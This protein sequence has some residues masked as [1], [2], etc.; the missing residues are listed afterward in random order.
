MSAA[1]Q[2]A[3]PSTTTTST[4]DTAGRVADAVAGAA[5]TPRRGAR[6]TAV[7]SG[8]G[9]V[10]KTFVAANL[11]AALARRGERVL[12]LDA[13][14]GLANLDVVLNLTARTTL[15]D[16]FTGRATLE[17][18]LQPAPGGFTVLL[19]GSG[20]IEY[21][22]MTPQVR[23]QLIALMAEVRPRFD[24]VLLDTGAGIADVVLFTVSLADELLVVTTPEPTALADAYATLKVLR[25][26][27]PARPVRLLVNQVQRAGDG[28]AVCSQL[29][30]VIDRFVNPGLAHPLVLLLA[31]EVPSDGAVREAVQRRQLVMTQLPGCPAAIALVAAAG[32]LAGP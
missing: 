29:Q 8:K 13:D 21:S 26:T 20:L 16:V 28:R 23:D 19:A 5:A 22:R 12:V 31:G 1:R 3:G 7:T 30:S 14:L 25:N 9:G 11:A 10:G 4:A 27:Q 2:P 15:H 18:A 32:K 17:Q 24:H 6:V